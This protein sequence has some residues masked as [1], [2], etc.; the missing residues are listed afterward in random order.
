MIFA[1]CVTEPRFAELPKFQTAYVLGATPWSDKDNQTDD[2]GWSPAYFAAKY[3]GV[4]GK[5]P[6]YQAVAAFA[7]GLLL[8]KAIEAAGSLEPQRVAAQLVGVRTRTVYG[9]VSFNA[10]RQNNAP[11]LTIQMSPTMQQVVVTAKTAIIPMPSWRQRQCEVANPCA[12]GCNPTLNL[13]S[14]EI[15]HRKRTS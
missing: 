6:P 11:F 12:S 14:M 3:Q 2:V 4:F 5:V 7:A 10:N 9:N 1:L 8:A 13:T 15:F